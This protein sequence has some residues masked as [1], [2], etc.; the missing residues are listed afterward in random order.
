MN[1]SQIQLF[2]FGMKT[3]YG[4]GAV[5]DVPALLFSLKWSLVSEKARQLINHF[6]RELCF[7]LFENLILLMFSFMSINFV[8]DIC[9]KAGKEVV[10]PMPIFVFLL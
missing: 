1:I 4:D 7:M 10:C 5:S 2:V 8:T 3:Y 6:T 9:L